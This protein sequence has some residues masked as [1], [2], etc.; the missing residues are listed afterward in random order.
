MEWPPCGG[1]EIVGIVQEIRFVV[2]LVTVESDSQLPLGAIVI[3]SEFKVTTPY[4]GGTTISQGVPSAPTTF[5]TTADN[6]PTAA[7][8]YLKHQDNPIVGLENVRVTIA[9]G[10]VVG[11]GVSITR[12]VAVP[13]A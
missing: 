4:S 3:D 1:G 8:L 13:L 9:G 12:F 2:G 6:N 11:A 10:P 5:M 7:D